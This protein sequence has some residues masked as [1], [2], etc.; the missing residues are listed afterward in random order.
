VTVSNRKS[1]AENVQVSTAAGRDARQAVAVLVS[2]GI[3]SVVLVAAEAQQHEVQPIYISCGL[4]WESSERECVA[5][6][7]ASYRAPHTIRPLATL[8][9]PLRDVYPGTHWSLRGGAPGYN[10]E[11]EASYLPGRNIALLAKAGIFCA[12]AQVGRIAMGQLAGNPFPDAT[13][14]FFAAMARALS[15][16]LDH[17]LEI[18]FP[19]LLRS[20]VDVIRLGA[21]LHVPFALT[22]SCL[23]PNGRRHCGACNKCRERREGFI[24]SGLEDPTTY[25]AVQMGSGVI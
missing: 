22:V 14:E 20:K 23:R 5:E 1:R 18:T 3:D 17:P 7:L 9:L 12:S 6:F 25:E 8:E 24:D 4:S 21:S 19:L 16:G 10:A 11:V 2:G 15:L 13:P